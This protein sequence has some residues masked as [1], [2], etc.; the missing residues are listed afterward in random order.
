MTQLKRLCVAL[1]LSGWLV[2]AVGCS[3]DNGGCQSTPGTTAGYCSCAD[4]ASCSETCPDGQAACSLYCANHNQS[5]SLTGFDEC[6]VACQ[7][8]T[9][10]SVDCRDDAN[11]ACQATGK[12]T[13]K[14]GNNA[15]IDCDMTQD[16]E[17]TC[18]GS[19]SVLCNGGHCRV[20]CADPATCDLQCAKQGTTPTLCPDGQTK[21]CDAAC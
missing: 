20:A 7:G 9:H 3:S 11:I 4:G 13:A 6:A 14:V 12:C 15:T 16:C 5:C 2:L 8:A 10:C 19:C 17:I 18:E 1:W 21:T